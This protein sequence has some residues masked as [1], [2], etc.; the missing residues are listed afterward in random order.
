LAKHHRTGEEA[1]TNVTVNYQLASGNNRLLGWS[2]SSI[3]AFADAR[4]F[5]VSGTSSE[6]IGTNDM[7]GYL[8]H[9]GWRVLDSGRR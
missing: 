9:A 6:T 1:G 8:G 5:D 7:F 2:T 3:N 4:R